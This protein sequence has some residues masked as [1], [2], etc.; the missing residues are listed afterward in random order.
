MNTLGQTRRRAALAL[1]LV[2]GLSTLTASAVQ[3]DDKKKE[4]MPQG[5]AV[6]WQDPGDISARNLLAGPG[7][8]MKPD[9][10]SV[11]FVKDEMGG[12]SPKFRVTDGAGKTW[13]AKFGK[14]A[15]PETAAVRLAWA[16]GYV[17]EVAHLVPC[18]QIKNAPEPRKEVERCNGKGFANVRFEARP[19]EWKRLDNWSWKEN[20]FA[21]QKEFQGLIVMMG[22]I[23]NWDLKDANNKIVYVPGAD[24]ASGEL[25]YLISDLGA[26]FGKTGNFITHDRNN[27]KNF[28]K[29]KFIE[30]V[31][32]GRVRFSYDGKNTGLFDQISV[33][34]AR[35]I[36]DQLA[37]LSDKQIEDAF[38]A[39]NYAGADLQTLVAEVRSRNNELTAL[40]AP[41]ATAG[42][43]GS[44]TPDKR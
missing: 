17:T 15:Q 8:D 23:N 34:N 30:G 33:E 35:W 4:P 41:A 7:P 16:V 6:L 26:T 3:K 38:R 2:L 1:A 42:T 28:A 36:G 20:P 31:E 5:T 25:R 24:A 14:E 37:R 10:S 22:L 40:P 29:S 9:L 32:G 44:G 21:G 39:A 19:D 12:Y 27:P 43:P 13:V 18:V 11:T